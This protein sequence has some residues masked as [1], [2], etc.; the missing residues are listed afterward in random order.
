MMVPVLSYL[1]IKKTK[2][3]R[4]S[5]ARFFGRKFSINLLYYTVVLMLVNDIDGMALFV[6]D[7]F[8]F[9]VHE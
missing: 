8:L 1:E 9:V 7:R 6:T 5:D 4:T 2:K 3:K